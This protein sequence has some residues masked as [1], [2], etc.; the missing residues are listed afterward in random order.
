[1]TPEAFEGW[2]EAA[3]V[4][5]S[6]T[7]HIGEGL[8][9]FSPTHHSL[10][11]DAVRRAYEDGKVFLS[12]DRL[13]GAGFEFKAR[14]ISDDTFNRIERID[15]QVARKERKVVDWRTRQ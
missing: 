15:R 12:Q 3:T 14:R 5:D 8:K 7:Y 9:D 4:G 10:L 6:I 2:L 13:E 1:M 11:F